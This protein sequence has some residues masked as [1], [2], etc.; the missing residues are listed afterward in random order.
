MEYATRAG[1]VTSRYYGETE[2][3]LGQY[4]WYLLNA[5]DRSRPVGRKKPN[6]FGFFDMHGNV[7]CWCQGRFQEYP[8]TTGNKA[9]EDKE[10]VSDIDS[11]FKLPLRG[12][13]FANLPPNVRS[14]ERDG[15]FPDFR[16]VTVGFRPART[17]T[18]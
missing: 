6:D 8:K 3:L 16:N 1:A 4:A 7:S 12:G 17:I 2:E 9:V 18:P 14:A 11:S 5:K 13:S 10:D 15:V